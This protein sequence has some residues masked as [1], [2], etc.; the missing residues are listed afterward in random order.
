MRELISQFHGRVLEAAESLNHRL[1]NLRENQDRGWLTLHGDYERAGDYYYF[2]TMIHRL[3]LLLIQLQQFQNEAIF[4][5]ARIAERTDLLFL[6][7]AKALEWALTDVALFSGLNYDPN[8]AT[9]H[10]FKGHIRVACEV[11]TEDVK[12]LSLMGFE[13]CLRN[14]KFLQEMTP[15]YMFFDGMSA[16]G[17]LRWDRLVA[18]HLLLCA[19]INTF[20]YPMQKTSKKQLRQIAGTVRHSEVLQNLLHWINKLGINKDKE[21]RF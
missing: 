7:Y 19:F 2:R 3:L 4:I 14:G 1:W 18:F 12:S 5:D 15:L 10:L 9:D 20:G 21:G 13:N 6:K 17:R 11:C 8:N 16:D